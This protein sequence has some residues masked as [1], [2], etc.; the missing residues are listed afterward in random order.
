MPLVGLFA[1]GSSQPIEYGGG[2]VGVADACQRGFKQTK[3]C[4]LMSGWLE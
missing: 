2:D 1:V 4:R 3:Q